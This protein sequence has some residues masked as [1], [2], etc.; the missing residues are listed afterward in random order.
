MTQCYLEGN[1]KDKKVDK[2]RLCHLACTGGSNNNENKTYKILCIKI[3]IKELTKNICKDT[4][5]SIDGV[6]IPGFILKPGSSCANTQGY[7]DIFSKCRAV[8][9][10]GPLTKLLKNLNNPEIVSTAVDWITVLFFIRIQRVFA[11]N[12]LF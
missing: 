3:Y 4:F 2:E 6:S 7:C 10:E 11:I 9:A 5:D 1:V 12:S 8:D